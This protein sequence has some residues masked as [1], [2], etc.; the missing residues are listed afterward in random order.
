MSEAWLLKYQFFEQWKCFGKG[1][2]FAARTKKPG[3]YKV[4]K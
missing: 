4:V 1:I 3:C 2:S